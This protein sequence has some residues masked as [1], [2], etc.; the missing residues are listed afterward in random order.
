MANPKFKPEYDDY[1][2]LEQLSEFVEIDYFVYQ[3]WLRN[4]P[5]SLTSDSEKEHEEDPFSHVH[6]IV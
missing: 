4:H 6:H 1:P 3:Q 5:D 2:N